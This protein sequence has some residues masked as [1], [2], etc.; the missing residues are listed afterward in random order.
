MKFGTKWTKARKRK[1]VRR[2]AKGKRA[3]ARVAAVVDVVAVAEAAKNQPLA[4]VVVPRVE[5]LRLAVVA[6]C[7]T[8]KK[9]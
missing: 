1:N 9:T 3:S 2:P 7:V 8:R 5:R 6:A 4:K